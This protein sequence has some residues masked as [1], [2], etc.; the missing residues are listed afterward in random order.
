MA[1]QI[2]HLKVNFRTKLRAKIESMLVMPGKGT[3]LVSAGNTIEVAKIVSR[4]TGTQNAVQEINFFYSQVAGRTFIDLKSIGSNQE[5]FLAFDELGRAYIFKIGEEEPLNLI[6]NLNQSYSLL[7]DFV[8]PYNSIFILNNS[9]SEHGFKFC[10][11]NK[12]SAIDA[13]TERPIPSS[14]IAYPSIQIVDAVP[15]ESVT[16]MN[17]AQISGRPPS[18]VLWKINF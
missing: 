14:N 3:L 4:S 15:H 5:I 12:K 2:D 17:I 16:F 11:I 13:D 10:D 18:V 6:Q 8:G 9:N 7:L 1:Y